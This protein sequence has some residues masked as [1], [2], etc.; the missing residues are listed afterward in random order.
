MK[1]Y[2]IFFLS[3]TSQAFSKEQNLPE[4]SLTITHAFLS[5][6]DVTVADTI[7]TSSFTGNGEII[8]GAQKESTLSLGRYAPSQ[9]NESKIYL[10]NLRKEPAPA[11]YLI[12]YSNNQLY[13][14]QSIPTE[15]QKNN[16]NLEL[17]M[18]IY[19]EKQLFNGRKKYL[20]EKECFFF[21][22]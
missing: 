3:L 2:I 10:K 16:I 11:F 17:K 13:K 4:N 1:Q 19:K 6:E 21:T 15:K 12:L 14:T 22:I 5:C 7:I 9:E 8:L 18:F 20:L